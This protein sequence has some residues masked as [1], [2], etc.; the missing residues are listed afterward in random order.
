[1]LS[2]TTYLVDA[3]HLFHRPEP[4][5]AFDPFC[6]VHENLGGTHEVDH[7][8]LRALFVRVDEVLRCHN[9]GAISMKDV[10]DV[11]T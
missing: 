5:I 6:L 8:L 11:L 2:T 9:L 1:M 3:L 10:D 4:G 7:I